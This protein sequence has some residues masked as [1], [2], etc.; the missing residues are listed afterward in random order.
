MILICL[1]LKFTFI[2]PKRNL[3][4]GVSETRICPG[5]GP[6]MSGSVAGHVR[7]DSLEP[8]QEAGYVRPDRRFW[9]RIDL[10]YLHF[11]NSL[12]H[13]LWAA[14]EEKGNGWLCSRIWDNFK[15]WSIMTLLKIHDDAFF[16]NDLPPLD[17]TQ[18]LYM[19]TKIK[20]IWRDPPICGDFTWNWDFW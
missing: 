5:R 4:V 14:M 13:S 17:A 6:D 19:I 18:K 1:T 16:I 11:T 15:N 9:W 20:C 8:G 12:R 3:P 7:Q 2:P 10:D